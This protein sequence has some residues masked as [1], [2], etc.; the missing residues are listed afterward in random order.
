V[1]SI[2]V[3]KDGTVYSLSRFRENGRMRTDLIR[4]DAQ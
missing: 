3:T 4:I 2:A 1:N